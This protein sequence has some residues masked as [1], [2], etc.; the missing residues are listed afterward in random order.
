M[1]LSGRTGASPALILA[2]VVFVCGGSCINRAKRFASV[3]PNERVS[4]ARIVS[5]EHHIFRYFRFNF[6]SCEYNFSADGSFYI[7]NDDC[8]QSM[9][10][11]AIKCIRGATGTSMKAYATVYYDPADP[12]VNSLLEFSAASESY[13]RQAATLICVG[14]LIVIF[15]VFGKILDSTNKSGKGGVIVD[16]RG[17]VI[18][19]EEVGLGSDFAG[20]PNREAVNSPSSAGLRELYL[21]VANKIHPDR[22]ASE[23]DLAMRERLMKEANA[24]FERSD[25]PTL[26]GILEE[27]RSITPA[28]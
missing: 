22:A 9:A 25:A 14:A 24:A 1:S 2:I 21:E 20:L 17:A 3:A 12:S 19:P 7:E 11:D 6:N 5:V 13:Y 16:A 18:N 4:T 27:Y 28:P 15:F 8:P 26:R 23:A 10:D